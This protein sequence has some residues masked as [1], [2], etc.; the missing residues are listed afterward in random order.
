MFEVLNLYVVGLVLVLLA[1]FSNFVSKIVHVDFENHWKFIKNLFKSEKIFSFLGKSLKYSGIE[2]LKYL[3]IRLL[4]AFVFSMVIVLLMVFGNG[5]AF[6]LVNL[7]KLML[8]VELV[9]ILSGIFGH[10]FFW[11]L[12]FTSKI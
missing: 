1:W 6:S 8:F 7:F 10:V 5:T 12:S 11:I 9:F 4:P 2:F 3:K